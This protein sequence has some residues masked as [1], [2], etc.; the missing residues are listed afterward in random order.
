M[1]TAPIAGGNPSS[2]DPNKGV[3]EMSIQWLS[4]KRVQKYTDLDQD[5]MLKISLGA[6][7]K[8]II[9]VYNQNKPKKES[10]VGKSSTQ[11]G[12]LADGVDPAEK[13]G[14]KEVAGSQFEHLEEF[15]YDSSYD[16]DLQVYQHV[17]KVK[18][19][20]VKNLEQGGVSQ[21]RL[22]KRKLT[23]FLLFFFRTLPRHEIIAVTTGNAWESIRPCINYRAPIKIAERI[24]DPNRIIEITRSCLLGPGVRETIHNP[25]GWEVGKI[26]NIYYLIES[27]RCAAKPNSSFMELLRLKKSPEVSIR[28]GNLRIHKKIPLAQYPA[29]LDLFSKYLAGKTTYDSKGIQESSSQRF[30]F[31]HFLKPVPGAKEKLDLQLATQIWK[32]FQAEQRQPFSFRHKYFQNYF[33]ATVYEIKYL[34]AARFQKL[35]GRPD[36]LEEIV[37]LI[38]A[39]EEQA[40]STA[41]ALFEALKE[42]KFRYQ[43][44]NNKKEMGALIEYVE[45]EVRDTDGNAYFKI[46]GMWFKLALDYHALLHEDFKGLLRQALIKPTEEG[47]LPRPWKGN[48]PQGKFSERKLAEKFGISKGLRKFVTDLKKCKS[49]FVNEEGEIKQKKLVGEI[50]KDPII[51]GLK[52]IIEDGILDGDQ[53]PSDDVIEDLLGEHADKVMAELRKKRPILKENKNGESYVIN[54]FPYPLK[55]DPVVKA[56]Y[57]EFVQY[58]EELAQ[59]Y[60]EGVEDEETYNRSYLSADYGHK[61]GFL[62]FD[63]ICPH[64]IEP[65]DVIKFTKDTTYLYHIK[66]TFGQ[67]TRDACSQILNA[68]K[69]VRS[70]LSVQQADHFLQLLWKMGTEKGLKGWKLQ[71]KQQLEDLGEAEFFKIFQ[72]RKIVFVYALLEQPNQSLYDEITT[73]SRLAPEDFDFG[74][75]EEQK[76]F[77]GKLKEESFLDSNGRITG[78]FYSS[79]QEKFEI[80]GANKK[81]NKAIY[82]KIAGYKSVSNSTLAKFEVLNVA[83]EVRALGFEF[84]L[85]QIQQP[86]GTLKSTGSWLPESFDSSILDSLDFIPESTSTAS[87]QVLGNIE[88]G[89]AG[90][91]NIGNSC[92][93]NATLQAIFNIPE[94]RQAIETFEVE[95]DDEN[96]NNLISLLQQIM[97]PANHEG[98]VDVRATLK[99]FRDEVFK[100][101]D[102][103]EL[104]GGKTAQQDAHEFLQF[105]LDKLNWRPIRLRTKFATE[106]EEWFSKGTRTNH[107]S[108]GLSKTGIFQDALDGYFAVENMDVDANDKIEPLEHGGERQWEQKESIKDPLPLHLTIHLKRFDES[109]RKTEQKIRFPANKKVR[110]K[111]DDDEAV[112]YEIVAFINHHGTTA[113]SGHY[114]ADIKNYRDP[115]GQERWVHCDDDDLQARPSPNGKDAYLVVLK[116]IEEEQSDASHSES[117]E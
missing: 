75:Q 7:V 84:K 90:L 52:A 50:L 66:E 92:Y 110:I 111:T 108:I 71:V 57:Q 101:K 26:T 42:I 12:D 85:C 11:S 99:K 41:D 94:I 100:T 33:D 39:N 109:G 58:L 104:T 49:V 3:Q 61:K 115:A 63:Q 47:Q 21:D 96:E 8:R 38:E 17:E 9:K 83:R 64:N 53:I 73:K 106:D 36:S 113:K 93:M 18:S 44:Q 79:S 60:L 20:L 48:K 117:S 86:S 15:K 105:I 95:D 77:F 68:A 114:T 55:K 31:L 35:E 4:L 98:S 27:F 91:W 116:K 56:Q 34:E 5:A 40:L 6:V 59:G 112:E 13:A 2:F 16:Y 10:E 24:L 54:P 76:D 32:A 74:T 97:Q 102:K 30:E 80:P 88:D 67:H 81:T 28:T 72:E 103:G 29:I 69:E 43:G 70:A 37:Q 14:E 23:D 62:V 89:P 87:S 65:C 107:L 22:H 78:K 1:A 46:R 25:F 51:A 19:S 45:G 82:D